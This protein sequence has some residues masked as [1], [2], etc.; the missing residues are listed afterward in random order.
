MQCPPQH[1]QTLVGPNL[2]KIKMSGVVFSVEGK[3][4]GADVA[5]SDKGTGSV[6]PPTTQNSGN[7]QESSPC[8]SNITSLLTATQIRDVNSNNTGNTEYWLSS[9]PLKHISTAYS[10]FGNTGYCN[11]CGGGLPGKH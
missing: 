11:V 8:S 9:I 10:F 4:C 7:S 1:P 3:Q 2:A 6:A 5:R